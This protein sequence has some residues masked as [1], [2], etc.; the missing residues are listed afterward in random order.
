ME[1]RPEDAPRAEES[2]EESRRQEREREDLELRK[3][4][5]EMDVRIQGSAPRRLRISKSAIYMTVL[6]LVLLFFG[7]I[8]YYG[9]VETR[10]FPEIEGPGRVAVPEVG[11]S[12]IPPPGFDAAGVDATGAVARWRGPGGAWMEL[13][14]R[15]LREY[16]KPLGAQGSRIFTSVLFARDLEER[17]D[18]ETLRSFPIEVAGQ[19]GG[20]VILEPSAP[21]AVRRVRAYG[22]VGRE[23]K[24]LLLGLPE[25]VLSETA[26]TNVVGSLRTIAR[27]IPRPEDEAKKGGDAAPDDGGSVSPGE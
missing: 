24:E 25:G 26:I 19:E 2:A 1:T 4:M 3:A 5:Q 23:V 21:E 18:A 14:V 16:P 17:Y 10:V 7:L 27:R 22:I 13:R 6:L 8:L 20:A 15:P 9:E 11:L 12:V